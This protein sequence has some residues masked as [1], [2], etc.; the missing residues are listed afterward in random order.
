M[1]HAI[2]AVSVKFTVDFTSQ[3][4]DFSIEESKETRA[5]RNLL[6]SL[7]LQAIRTV[8]QGAMLVTMN[9][10][11]LLRGGSH[12]SFNQKYIG[13]WGVSGMFYTYVPSDSF[14]P[15]LPPLTLALL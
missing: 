10:E 4:I 13:G 5:I 2:S 7:T 6:F 3:A 1:I 15:P 11:I 14:G 9:L 8:N 12:L